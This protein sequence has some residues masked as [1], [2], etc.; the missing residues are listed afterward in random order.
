MAARSESSLCPKCG[1]KDETPNRHVSSC[2]FYQDI[3]IKYFGNTITTVHNVVAKCYINKLVTYLKKAE[4]LAEF[5]H[6]Q[7]KTT[8]AAIVAMGP[9]K[10]KAMFKW[11]LI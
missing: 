11:T 5:D 7:N 4:K 8:A 3:L 2:K 10:A 9:D 1:P 6:K